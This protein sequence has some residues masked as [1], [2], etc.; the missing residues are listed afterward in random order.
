MKN[1]NLSE[2]H[3]SFC[4]ASLETTIKAK[5]LPAHDAPQHLHMNDRIL[6][7]LEQSPAALSEAKRM[8]L[9]S[10]C[11][12]LAP[13]TRYPEQRQLTV[14]TKIQEASLCKIQNQKRDN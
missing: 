8:T 1:E 6:E 9:P 3:A 11:S 12:K 14:T 13:A 5:L 2:V 10:T 4:T 7:S